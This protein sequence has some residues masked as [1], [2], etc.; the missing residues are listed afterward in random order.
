MKLN[1]GIT[2]REGTA[3]H[4][5]G[6]YSHML[7]LLDPE[8]GYDGV[9]CPKKVETLHAIYFH[10]LDDIE[11]QAPEYAGCI[12]PAENHVVEV[13]EF[14]EMT[15]KQGQGILIN[16]EAGISR[17]TAAAMI[18][19]TSLGITPRDAFR[20]V[21]AINELGLPNRR[22]LRL[23]SKYLGDHGMLLELAEAQRKYLFAKYGQTDP[24]EIIRQRILRERCN[25]LMRT[26]KKLCG[27]ATLGRQGSD[28]KLIN[29]L[30]IKLAMQEM[31]GQQAMEKEP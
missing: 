5:E 24:T 8:R 28:I 29:R 23:A 19:L 1:L 21:T 31:Q 2:S 20:H 6:N 17:S 26:W 14:F 22:M 4:K 3:Q 7:S 11:M 12:L 27:Y 15:R 16:C 10:D 18:G 30:K 25:W 9:V 13:L